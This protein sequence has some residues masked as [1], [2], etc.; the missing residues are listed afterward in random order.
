MREFTILQHNHYVWIRLGLIVLTIVASS[1]VGQYVKMHYLVAVAPTAIMILACTIHHIYHENYKEV[2]LFYF[3]EAGLVIHDA[4][5][6][7]ERLIPIDELRKIK[8]KYRSYYGEEQ[9]LPF[10][11]KTH[12]RSGV[13]NFIEV[14]TTKGRI[15]YCFY[16]NNAGD[17]KHLSQWAKFYQARGVHMKLAHEDSVF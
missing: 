2:G 10:D 13:D 17:R 6:A 3:G 9:R 15:N 16:G 8:I 4:D 1:I 5:S 11:W 14:E 12:T 7:A